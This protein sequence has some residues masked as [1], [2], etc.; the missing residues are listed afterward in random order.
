MKV[1]MGMR[2]LKKTALFDLQLQDQIF[3]K[4]LTIVL[5]VT[6]TVVDCDSCDHINPCRQQRYDLSR[7]SRGVG[8][9]FVIENALSFRK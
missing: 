8:Q 2:N 5:G 7:S 3:S 4:K 1:N 9:R 6:T